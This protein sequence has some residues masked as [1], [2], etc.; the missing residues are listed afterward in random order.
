MLGS[1]AKSII[2]APFFIIF[3]K[4]FID[5]KK[6]KGQELSLVGHYFFYLFLLGRFATICYITQCYFLMSSC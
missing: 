2:L 4:S 6:I 1:T 5:K 3:G